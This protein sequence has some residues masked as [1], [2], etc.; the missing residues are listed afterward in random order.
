[1]ANYFENFGLQQYG[2][3]SEVS[4]KLTTRAN[5]AQSVISRSR[6]FYPYTIKA[7]E[8]PDTLSFLYYKKPDLEWL[9]FFANDIID[10]YYDWHLTDDA[11]NSFIVSKYGSIAQ[12]QT[13]TKHYE[14]VW[15][16]DDSKISLDTYSLLA[17]NTTVN[18]KKY[19]EPVVDDM[20]RATSYRRKKLEIIATTNRIINIPVASINGTF[21]EGEDVYQESDGVITAAASLVTANTTYFTAQHVSG[22]FDVAKTL[23]GSESL[24]NAAITAIPTTL[25]INIPTEELIYWQA[26]SFYEYEVQL[27]E[28]RKH[29]KLINSEYADM[30]EN[31]LTRLMT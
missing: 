31:D 23:L 2:E 7:G 22:S 17:A 14:V 4:R 13:K 25:V 12:A 1:M 18:I 28:K 26:V 20:N 11:F 6:A 5:I 29:I 15:A 10:P 9:I 21:V 19:W 27:N 8:R 24:A 30:A 3:K 16:G